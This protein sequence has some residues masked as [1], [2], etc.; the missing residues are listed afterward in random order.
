MPAPGVV[1]LDSG[2]QLALGLLQEAACDQLF[3]TS[4]S[5]EMTVVF[6]RL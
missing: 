5:T 2:T 3:L 4:D 1:A 6:L